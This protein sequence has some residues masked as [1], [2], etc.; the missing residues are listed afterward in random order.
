MVI[1][2]V[3]PTLPANPV[4]AP[5]I[6]SMDSS[7]TRLSNVYA[8]SAFIPDNPLND[9]DVAASASN[10]GEDTDKSENPG[11]FIRASIN[12]DCLIESLTP[13]PTLL[14]LLA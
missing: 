14:D 8:L 10:N 3:I 7:Y 5:R 9:A 1:G 2:L 4:D 13:L 12:A 11:S 6:P